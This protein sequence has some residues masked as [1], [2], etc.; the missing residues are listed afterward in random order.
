[1]DTSFEVRLP[2]TKLV[3]LQLSLSS[4]ISKKSCMKK[5]LEFHASHTIQPGKIFMGRLFTLLSGARR[6]HHHI[7]P[8]QAT[9]SDL[10]WWATFISSWNGISIIPSN[11]TGQVP[12]DVR[13]D[14]FSYNGPSLA[15][16]KDGNTG[17]KYYGEGTTAHHISLYSLGSDQYGAAPL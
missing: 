7:Q 11:T 6:A 5:E 16:E 2:H 1:M 14:G 4:W 17:C 9:R 15:K 8:S 12:H 3:D 13:G 10:L